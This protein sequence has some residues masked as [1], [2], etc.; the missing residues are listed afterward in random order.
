MLFCHDFGPSDGRPVVLLHPANVAGQIW[1]GPVAALG[2]VRGFC[3]DLPGFGGSVAV[4]FTGFEDAADRVAEVI[5]STVPGSVPVVGYSYGAYVA[6]RLALRHPDLVD[7]MMFVSGQ[8]SKIKGAWW[9]VP[10]T[11]AMTPMVASRKARAKGL[12]ALGITQSSGWLP[13]DVGACNALSLFKVGAAALRFE[14]KN[15]ARTLKMPVLALAG[16]R[17]HAA[18]RDTISFFEHGVPVAS[19]RLAE[20]GHAWPATAQS[21]FTDCVRAFLEN[22]PLPAGLMRPEN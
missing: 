13:D 21:L 6:L 8:V 19:G 18:I 17:E 5:R 12:A 20:G 22:T 9:M 2:D 16:T 15:A 10:M 7:R 11:A 14:A 3:P 4:P 1:K